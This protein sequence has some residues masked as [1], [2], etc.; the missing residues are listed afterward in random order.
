M[1]TS[2]FVASS[3]RSFRLTHVINASFVHKTTRASVSVENFIIFYC[4]DF[5]CIHHAVRAH[6]SVPLGFP[7][8]LTCVIQRRVI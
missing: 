5:Y 1:R 4:F 8:L 6:I 3:T 2:L 7:F